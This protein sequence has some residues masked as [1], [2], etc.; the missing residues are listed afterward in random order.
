MKFS[1][2]KCGS[3]MRMQVNACISAPSDLMHDFKKT[4]LR[5]KDVYFMGVFWETATHIC[6][7]EKCKNVIDG[8]IN[9]I[10]E[11][12]VQN[13]VMKEALQKIHE[14]AHDVSTGPAVPDVY[15]EIRELAMQ[16]L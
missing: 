10:D 15:W 14:L 12:K 3:S 9:W 7:N 5:R 4:N 16:M 11:M 2:P 6:S 13:E 1:C 8:Y